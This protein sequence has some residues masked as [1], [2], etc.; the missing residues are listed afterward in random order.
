M[1]KKL[2]WPYYSGTRVPVSWYTN[3]AAARE[4]IVDY[5]SDNAARTVNH[6]ILIRPRRVSR[7]LQAAPRSA[8][9]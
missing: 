5:W 2:E 7:T 4:A 6:P 8:A 1:K 3:W 9:K